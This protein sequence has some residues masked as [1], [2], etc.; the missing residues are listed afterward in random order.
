MA[1]FFL[2]RRCAMTVTLVRAPM[3]FKRFKEWRLVMRAE[4]RR[5]RL[6]PMLQLLLSFRSWR[7]RRETLRLL[8]LCPGCPVY[9][10]SLHQCRPYPGSP[11][12]CGCYMPTKVRF[13]GGCWADDF[14]E[15]EMG[16]KWVSERSKTPL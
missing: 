7:G 5:L 13:G 16:W 10:R 6:V 14:P 12:G 8:R 4:S 1:F 2:L 3:N 11:L 15:L 9:N